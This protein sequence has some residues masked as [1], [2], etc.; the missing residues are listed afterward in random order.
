MTP[1]VMRGSDEVVIGFESG[2]GE[3]EES[4]EDEKSTN[5]DC[6]LS[7]GED[8]SGICAFEEGVKGGRFEW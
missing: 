3:E 8:M 2:E 4:E 7:S 6:R 5:G 1:I